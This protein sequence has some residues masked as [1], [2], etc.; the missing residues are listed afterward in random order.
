MSFYISG[1]PNCPVKAFTLYFSRLHPDR[2]DF[3][4]R[5]RKS[6]QVKES[7]DI[8]YETAPVGKNTLGNLM[9]K[10]S[11]D[12]GLSRKYKNHCIRSTCITV[13]DEGGVETRHIIGLS[14]H[15]SESS[16]K[17]YCSRLSDIK[18]RELS[19]ILSETIRTTTEPKSLIPAKPKDCDNSANNNQQLLDPETDFHSDDIA[20]DSIV[21]DISE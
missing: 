5:P 3:W 4:Q 2:N 20:F 1:H 17:S 19:E 6:G 14:G 7:D 18:K 9:V 15:K 8:W 13:L 16:V 10:I 21:K 11:E 12:C